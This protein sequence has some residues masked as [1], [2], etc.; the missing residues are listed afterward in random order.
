MNMIMW[1]TI[2]NTVGLVLLFW[3]LLAHGIAHAKLY[4]ALQQVEE[5]IDE[6]FNPSPSKGPDGTR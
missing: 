5:D 6:I 1:V 4:K 3:A 2:A